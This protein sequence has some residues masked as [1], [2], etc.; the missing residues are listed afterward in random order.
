VQSGSVRTNTVNP[1]WNETFGFFVDFVKG[2]PTTPSIL[3]AVYHYQPDG[4]HC[5]NK[6]LFFLQ[7][8]KKRDNIPLGNI[9]LK[10][11]DIPRNEVVNRYCKLEGV[12]SGEVLIA[13]QRHKIIEMQ[14]PW[15]KNLLSKCGVTLASFLGTTPWV[16]SGDSPKNPAL[17]HLQT[18]INKNQLDFTVDIILVYLFIFL[19]YLKKKKCVVCVFF[20]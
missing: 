16:L 3:F 10:I 19:I 17:S 12:G 8:K 20:F 15:T 14:Q 4:P 1:T 5:Y 18:V 9:H 13:M 7:K 2:L 6:H 11:D